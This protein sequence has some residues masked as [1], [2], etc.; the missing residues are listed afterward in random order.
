MVGI[1]LS[2][3]LVLVFLPWEHV[4]GFCCGEELDHSILEPVPV[5]VSR[6]ARFRARGILLV[7]CHLVTRLLHAPQ[8]MAFHWG[9]EVP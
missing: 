7:L 6:A 8:N 3:S 1:A 2:M 4:P 9:L 5:D